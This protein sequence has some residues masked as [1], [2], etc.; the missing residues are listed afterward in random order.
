MEARNDWV[1]WILEE[2]NWVSMNVIIRDNSI[3]PTEEEIMNIIIPR[4]QKEKAINKIATL[5]DQL[6]M[7]ALIMEEMV[8]ERKTIT[9]TMQK[10]LDMTS[11][12]KAILNK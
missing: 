10:G 3:E 7:L 4:K 11:G 5:T 2:Y 12:I 9:P 8:L 6:N 1:N